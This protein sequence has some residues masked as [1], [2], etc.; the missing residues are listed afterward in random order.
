MQH[1]RSQLVPIIIGSCVVFFAGYF[2]ASFVDAA[3]TAQVDLGKFWE[4]SSIMKSRYP[5][6]DKIPKLSDQIDGAIS[7]LVSSYGDPYTTYLS[8]NQLSS[9]KDSVQGSFSGIGI[10]VGMKDGLLTVIAP[11]KGSPAE[12]A[13]FL[14]GDIIYKIN[15]EDVSTVSIDDIIQKIRGPKGTPISIEIIRKD[16]AKPLVLTPIRDTIS[17][18]TTESKTVDNVDV[19]ALYTFTRESVQQIYDLFATSEKNNRD[20]IIIDLRGNPGGL[21]D[22]ATEIAS[23]ILPKNTVLVRE[24]PGIENTAED[25][26][27]SEGY[28]VVDTN[29]RLVV[30]LNEGSASASEILAGALQDHERATIVGSK[31]FGKGSV[32]EIVDL[33]DG[34]GIKITVAKWYTPDN[35]SISETGIVP[36]III[37]DSN[38]LDTTDEV[39]DRA[40]QFIKTNN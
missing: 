2:S 11:I 33:G 40:L 8:K 1:K 12:K 9:L 38:P 13:G 23:M 14:T 24:K 4:A 26:F 5:F 22:S 29:T 20:A 6:K 30:L 7:G 27:R 15:G 10:E 25:I 34:S 19:V 32:Q 28:N 16:T 21:L 17:I 36:D 18:P 31:S 37:E 39:L 3:T 35:V